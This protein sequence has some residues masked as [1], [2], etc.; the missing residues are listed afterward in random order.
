MPPGPQVGRG[1][2]IILQAACVNTTGMRLWRWEG[3]EE[4]TQVSWD[5][6]ESSQPG[7]EDFQTT[8]K[9]R[10]EQGR[11]RERQAITV[12]RQSEQ[13]TGRS[14]CV[15]RCVVFKHKQGHLM[16]RGTPAPLP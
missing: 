13:E 16:S 4:R 11:L 8:P 5:K 3:G 6:K 12:G 2:S 9:G 7:I 1:E 14:G 15:H 10:V